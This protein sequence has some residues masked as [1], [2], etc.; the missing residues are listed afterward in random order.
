MTN[1]LSTRDMSAGS[2]RHACGRPTQLCVFAP[3]IIS[4]VHSGQAAS[5]RIKPKGW[6]PS[7]LYLSLY[8][9]LFASTLTA[10][11]STALVMRSARAVLV[12]TALAGL[13]TRHVYYS[14]VTG[15]SAAGPALPRPAGSWDMPCMLAPVPV[16]CK[17]RPA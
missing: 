6:G 10:A 16:P 11:V 14:T 7:R 8:A 4:H 1:M 15:S 13:T 3:T 12:I 9:L 17:C 2:Q 5:C